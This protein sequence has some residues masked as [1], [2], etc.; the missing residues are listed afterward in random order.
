MGQH[1]AHTCHTKSRAGSKQG[2]Q[3]LLKCMKI[4][5]SRNFF[6][7]QI[8]SFEQQLPAHDALRTFGGPD[9]YRAVFIRAPAIL[10]TDPD[11][12]T[13][14]SEYKCSHEEV[15]KAG[16]DK[17]IVAAGSGNLLATAFHPE[18][19]EDLRWCAPG[20][21]SCKDNVFADEQDC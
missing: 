10:S 15:Q 8:S 2:G 1:H 14:L 4:R 5:V 21:E 6:G 9:T 16:Q 17:V 12:V 13:V 19:T 3:E 20:P 11:S 18:L 7:A